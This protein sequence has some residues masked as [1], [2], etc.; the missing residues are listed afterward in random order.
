M[1]QEDLITA[2]QTDTGT[3]PE[4]QTVSAH[5]VEKRSSGC[6]NANPAVIDMLRKST[7]YPY[8]QLITGTGKINFKCEPFFLCSEGGKHRQILAQ[9][10][11]KVYR[12]DYG[13]CFH[14]VEIA[15]KA[16]I[17]A[18]H[19]RN[20]AKKVF[21][22]GNFALKK[23]TWYS[24]LYSEWKTEYLKIRISQNLSLSHGIKPDLLRKLLEEARRIIDSKEL[25]DPIL[26]D[27]FVEWFIKL[28]EDKVSKI[29][30]STT[31][32]T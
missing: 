1:N 13:P 29:L 27:N 8:L 14:Q 28:P 25:T 5:C 12:G 20:V 26:H 22:T 31:A 15:A 6:L 10:M 21:G 3:L 16:L 2:V 18:C 7:L 30:S 4:S 17:P 11:V 24:Y 19:L 23:K 9:E 32:G